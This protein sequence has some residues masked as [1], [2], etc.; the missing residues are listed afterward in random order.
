[1]RNRWSLWALYALLVCSIP[2]IAQGVGDT[3]LRS[4]KNA[5]VLHNMTLGCEIPGVHLDIVCKDVG[6]PIEAFEQIRLS[7]GDRSEMVRK[8]ND[9]RGYVHITD[10]STA[11]RYVR[12]LTSPETWFL[13]KERKQTEMEIMEAGDALARP[14]FGLHEHGTYLGSPLKP[15]RILGVDRIVY[16]QYDARSKK[17]ELVEFPGSPGVDKALKTMSPPDLTILGDGMMGIVT[18]QA[19]RKGGFSPA[20]V[21]AVPG[22]FQVTRWLYVESFPGEKRRRSIKQVQEY[23]GAD[24]EYRQKV[25]KS[26][27]KIPSLPDTNFSMMHFE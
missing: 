21:V 3:F 4:E 8:L 9:V 10:G 18:R 14:N 6:L 25:L 24:G 27:S 7:H 15:M 22:G 12:L 1:M 2:C 20:T 16:W 13:W 17:M 5:L 11:L 26:P 19:F 23:V